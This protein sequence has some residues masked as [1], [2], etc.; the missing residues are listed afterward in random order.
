MPMNS[1]GICSTLCFGGLLIKQERLAILCRVL[2][3]KNP[4]LV[5]PIHSVHFLINPVLQMWVSL[6]ISDA[7]AEIKLKYY[8]YK[9]RLNPQSRT[10]RTASLASP[11]C[12]LKTLSKLHNC[13]PVTNPKH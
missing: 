11:V 7:G 12:G 5:G 4:R 8:I 9:K 10:L 6:P 3:V 2:H 13:G 1:D